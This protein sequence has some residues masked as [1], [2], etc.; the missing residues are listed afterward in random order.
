MQSQV[1]RLGVTL[2][3]HAGHAGFTG[4]HTIQTTS[5]LQ[6]QAERVVLCT[7]GTSRRLVVPGAELTSSVSDAWSLTGVPESMMVIGAGMT[8]VQV[9]SIFQSF[10][11]RVT[12]FQAAP[13]IL[14]SEDDDVSAAV[15]AAFRASGMVIRENCGTIESFEK[16]PAGVRV[17]LSKE[18]T[19]ESFEA[20]LAVVTIG[21]H[22]DTEALNLVRA[23]VK[24]DARGYI[25]VN[26]HLQTSA[27]HVYAAGD[28]TGRWMLAPQAMQ[29]GWV[30]GTN[31]GG[32]DRMTA[33][34]TV[35]PIGGFTDPEYARVG[36]TEAKAREMGDVVIATIGFDETT[37]TIIDGRKAGFCK[38]LVDPATR[39]IIGCHVVGER[40]VEIVQVAAIAMSSGMRVDELA[41]VPL[42]FPTYAGVLV[43]VSYRAVA[44]LGTEITG[45]PPDGTP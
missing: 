13:R 41:R 1:D 19:R 45:A 4:P 14:M 16:T 7:G 34:D 8:G 29:D 36:P 9:A 38:L 26:R 27:S 24:V 30:A 44:Q 21:W 6:I 25:A 32:A 39:R 23:D 42:S 40:A 37:R 33:D 17:T 15:A 20:A 5:G 2:H 43:R 31:A 11:S 18:D 3:E 22:A 28:V 10:G 12:L 35:C